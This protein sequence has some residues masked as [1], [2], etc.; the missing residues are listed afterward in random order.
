[1]ENIKHHAMFAQHNGCSQHIPFD[2][3]SPFLCLITYCSPSSPMNL[4]QILIPFLLNIPVWGEHSHRATENVKLINLVNYREQ[5]PV[6]CLK[7]QGKYSKG[8]RRVKRKEQSQLHDLPFS[9]YFTSRASSPNYVYQ[10][11]A[12]YIYT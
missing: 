1:M 10:T 11:R 6:N 4:I 2:V 5:L 8:Q 12:T 9:N 3:Y 7:P